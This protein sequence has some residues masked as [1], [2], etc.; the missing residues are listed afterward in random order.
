MI[1]CRQVAIELGRH[2]KA[3]VQ[4]D[5]WLAE[6]AMGRF[7]G[8]TWAEIEA[9]DGE[10]YASWMRDWRTMA[11]PEGESPLDLEKRVRSALEDL[12]ENGPHVFVTHAGVWRALEVITRGIS[13]DEA[14]AIAVPHL[15][16]MELPDL[17]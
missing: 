1:R 4:V 13:W 14:M 16:W 2:W 9:T 6:L 3:D 10:A 5:E 8:K 17:A 11:P 7:E 12:D 15:T